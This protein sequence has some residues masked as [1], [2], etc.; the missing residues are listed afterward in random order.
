MFSLGWGTPS[1][2]ESS[3]ERGI[4]A[5]VERVLLG[6]AFWLEQSQTHDLIDS[7]VA[8]QT[9]P[10][11]RSASRL[12]AR[13]PV[14]RS[15]SRVLFL[16][17]MPGQQRFQFLDSV[18]QF[19]HLTSFHRACGGGRWRPFASGSTISP[20]LTPVPLQEL[21]RVHGRRQGTIGV[22]VHVHHPFHVPQRVFLRCHG[23]RRGSC[24]ARR[25]GEKSS[26]ASWR[27]PLQ[28]APGSAGSRPRR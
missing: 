1:V 2:A 28:S 7:C 4:N 9:R 22:L 20:R 8:N 17:R 14:L 18:L 21:E 12:A 5:P 23:L 26:P 3:L 10:L 24:D 19:V 15:L 13:F 11:C 25:R 16:W 27:P 6:R